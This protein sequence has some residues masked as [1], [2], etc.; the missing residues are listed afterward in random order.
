M[1][2]LINAA[3]N[4]IIIFKITD[5][6]LDVGFY[7]SDTFALRNRNTVEQTLELKYSFNNKSSINIVGR[8]YWST[9]NNREFF[10]LNNYGTL[11]P[12]QTPQTI[13]HQNYNNFYINAV[14]TLQFAPGSF[15]NIVWKDEADIFERDLRQQYFKN[16]DHTLGSS[17]NNNLSVKIIYFLDYLDLKKWRKKSKNVG[18]ADVAPE[19]TTTWQRGFVRENFHTLVQ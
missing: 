9:V 4:V 18:R 6:A 5:I 14:Y 10:N 3:F 15:L 16:F 8:H 11:S 17:Q 19:S 13:R 1:H 7:S 12:V 2:Q